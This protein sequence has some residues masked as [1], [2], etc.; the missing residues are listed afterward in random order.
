M[1]RLAAIILAALWLGACGYPGYTVEAHHQESIEH[2]VDAR[3]FTR[4]IYDKGGV[5]AVE[6]VYCPIQQGTPQVVCRTA[7]VWERDKS[8]LVE[9]TR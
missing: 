9:G 4:Q 2:V 3:W 5:R 7:V 8:A 6:L 1:K